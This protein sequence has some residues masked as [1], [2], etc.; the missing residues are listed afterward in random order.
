MNASVSWHGVHLELMVKNFNFGEWLVL[1]QRKLSSL[2]DFSLEVFPEL[3][4]SACNWPDSH[5]RQTASRGSCFGCNMQRYKIDW[6]G[7]GNFTIK[8]TN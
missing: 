4:T 7:Q 6:Y 2:L 3:L 8:L 5:Q 1:Q